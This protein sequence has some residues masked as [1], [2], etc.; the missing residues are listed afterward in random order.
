[1]GDLLAVDGA[2]GW[3][4]IGR[5]GPPPV[6]SIAHRDVDWARVKAVT[7]L[8][9]QQFRYTYERPIEGLRHRLV[10]VPRRRHGTQHRVDS[11]LEITGV[12]ARTTVRSDGFGN[13]IVDVRAPSVPDWIEF[14]TWAVVRRRS[15]ATLLPGAVLT[16]PSLLEPSSLTRADDAI[17]SVAAELAGEGLPPLALAECITEWVH[18]A[19]RYAHDAT[20]VRTTAAEALALGTGVCQDYS[21][22]MLALCRTCGLPARYISGHLLGEGGSHAWVEV[23]VADP[24]RRHSALAVAFD[25]TNG[26]PGGFQY[27]TVAVGRDYRDVAPTSGTFRS[28]CSGRLQTRKRL[29]VTE[30]QVVQS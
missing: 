17:R 22:L 26:R 14:D 23:L 15:G 3:A 16:S 11:G 18:G 21:H 7:F 1:M 20:G 8:L 2:A 4:A 13:H 27:L 25:P 30:V 5:V 29:C 9:H 12:P 19:L 10:V 28:P 24:E 6:Q